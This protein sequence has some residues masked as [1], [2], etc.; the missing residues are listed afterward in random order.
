MIN[1]LNKFNMLPDMLLC[2]LDI[3]SLYTD[4]PQN[5][6]IQSTNDYLAIHRH[7]NALPHKAI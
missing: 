4:I 7:T 3:T 5:E 1:I 6:G 2:T